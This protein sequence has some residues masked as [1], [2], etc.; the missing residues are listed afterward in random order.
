MIKIPTGAIF[1]AVV[2]K[3]SLATGY[4]YNGE[5][6]FPFILEIFCAN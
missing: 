3:L 6:Y 5:V 2:Q 4:T 1:E